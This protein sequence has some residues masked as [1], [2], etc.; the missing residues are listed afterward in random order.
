MP[1]AHDRCRVPA[2]PGRTR[3]LAGRHERHGRQLVVVIFIVAIF[4][5]VIFIVVAQSP[6]LGAAAP[7]PGLQIGSRNIDAS[8]GERT[9]GAAS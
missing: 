2:G 7:M 4:V 6:P 8:S 9:A 5:V 3:E 1:A